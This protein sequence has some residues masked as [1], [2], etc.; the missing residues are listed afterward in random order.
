MGFVAHECITSIVTI[1]IIAEIISCP[2]H[3]LLITR[4]EAILAQ[5]ILAQVLMLA[6]MWH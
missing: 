2:P 5:A 1:T 4:T 6:R 3:N